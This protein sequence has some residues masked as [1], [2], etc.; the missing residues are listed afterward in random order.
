M[1]QQLATFLFIGVVGLAI[2]GMATF[3]IA[4]G[5]VDA[6]VFNTLAGTLIGGVVG[7]LAPSP[8]AVGKPP[9]PAP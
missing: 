1:S 2:L 9:V 4:T 8:I 5:K 3:L 6:S 7:L